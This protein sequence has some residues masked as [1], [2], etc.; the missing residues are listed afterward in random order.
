VPHANDD[1]DDV[2]DAACAWLGANAKHFRC[3]I[4]CVVVK[5]DGQCRLL[6]GVDAELDLTNA[7]DARISD[8]QSNFLSSHARAVFVVAQELDGMAR[9][10]TFFVPGP[11]PCTVLWGNVLRDYL[12]ERT[13]S[14]GRVW[15]KLLSFFVSCDRIRHA[16]RTRER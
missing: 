14:K 7:D 6:G 4:V 1:N 8:A 11:R 5:P 9:G 15:P 12:Y 3:D 10:L 16:Q 2:D 13:D